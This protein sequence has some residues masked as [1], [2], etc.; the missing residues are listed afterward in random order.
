M[1]LEKILV[2]MSKELFADK[3]DQTDLRKGN[4]RRTLLLSIF[5]NEPSFSLIENS[6]VIKM[7]ECIR[8]EFTNKYYNYV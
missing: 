3:N 2:Q 4:E 7:Y 8:G 6:I 1:I 5:K